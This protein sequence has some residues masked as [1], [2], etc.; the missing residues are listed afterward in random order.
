MINKDRI[1]PITVTDLLTMYGNIMTLAG[2]TVTSASATSPGVFETDDAS[3]NIL[4]NEP[5][6]SFD[7]GGTPDSPVLY[8]IPSYSY[9]GFTVGG[10]VAT[11][12]GDEVD[13]DGRTLYTATPSGSTVTIAKIGF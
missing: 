8:F 4:A 9:E 6:K 13:P 11:M 10:N 1:V 12:A 5:V 3:G 7:F 2:T